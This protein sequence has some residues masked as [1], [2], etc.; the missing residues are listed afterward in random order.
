M[1]SSPRTKDGKIIPSFAFIG[2]MAGGKNEY[3]DALQRAIEKEFGVSVFR[4]SFSA[5]ISLIA[6]DLFPYM[7]QPGVKP[8]RLLQEIGAKMNEIDPAVWAKYLVRQIIREDREPFIVDGIRRP[9]EMAVFKDGFPDFIAIR[10]D[11]DEQQR[12]EAYKKLHGRY[13]T[14]EEK[15]NITERTVASLPTDISIRNTYRRDDLE[16]QIAEIIMKIQDG[17]ILDV[18]RK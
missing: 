7:I 12:M 8:R 4:P 14:Q 10:L 13:P 9:E 6:Q 11:V 18:L 17:S 1:V 15:E 2:P 16:R 3:C 5:K